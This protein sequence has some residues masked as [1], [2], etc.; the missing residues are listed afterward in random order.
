[1]S[2]PRILALAAL[3]VALASAGC[4]GDEAPPP[5]REPVARYGADGALPA[6]VRPSSRPDVVLVVL[7]GVRRDAAL[8]NAA[9]VP[10]MPRLVEFAR[11]ATTFAEAASP[12]ATSEAGFASILTGLLPTGHGVQPRRGSRTPPLIPAVATLAEI[13]RAAGW[14]T[15]SFSEGGDVG[16]AK[17][18]DQGFDEATEGWRLEG[19]VDRVAAWWEAGKRDVP[20]LLVV[21]ADD[22]AEPYGPKSASAP[23]RPHEA[24][25]L[26]AADGAVA[27]AKDAGGVVDPA[28]ALALEWARV[29]S[30][31]GAAL[32]ATGVERDRLAEGFA[33]AARLPAMTG[34]GA[35]TLADE[36]TRAYRENLRR[37][38]GLLGD[39]LDRLT[40]GG[41]RDDAVVV[42]VSDCGCALGERASRRRFGRGGSLLEE[43]VHVPLA[44]RAK[45]RLAPGVVGGSCGT[46]DVAA[47]VLDLVGLPRPRDGDG[48]SLVEMAAHPDAPGVPVFGR[49]RAVEA[50]ADGRVEER[51]LVSV[52]TAK[53]K[54]VASLDLVTLKWT[55]EVYDRRTDPAEVNP[56]PVEWVAGLGADFGKAVAA[57]RD[58]LS[59]RREHLRDVGLEG[60]AIRGGG[61]AGGN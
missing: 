14:R 4:G 49:E 54:F 34:D 58:L 22:T 21:H 46:L 36:A 16:P 13:L 38:D 19:G 59:G 39:L 23:L 2:A 31:Q 9:I 3:A 45:G 29:S 7:A 48:R 20:A 8:G 26:A 18:F 53:G 37:V 17:G 60:Y 61:G 11:G 28:D 30:A 52:R 42:V 5:A 43:S 33:R 15:A 51:D 6:G 10:A 41:L 40:A 27:R 50:T 57:V 25:V 12:A 56:L 47:T 35:R 55:E 1:V 32:V 44:V 24:E